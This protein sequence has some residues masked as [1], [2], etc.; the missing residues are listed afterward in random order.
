L[1]QRGHSL[2][3]V[4]RAYGNQQVLLWDKPSGAVEAAS[5]PRGLGLASQLPVEFELLPA[6]APRLKLQASGTSP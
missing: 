1:Q 6:A 5:D 4:E 3:A 2:K